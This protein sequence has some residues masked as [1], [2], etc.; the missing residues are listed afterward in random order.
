MQLGKLKRTLIQFSFPEDHR[1]GIH[2]KGVPG[3]NLAVLKPSSPP[4]NPELLFR[5][6]LLLLTSSTSKMNHVLG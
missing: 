3:G 5:E 6:H 1:L 4:G 2:N